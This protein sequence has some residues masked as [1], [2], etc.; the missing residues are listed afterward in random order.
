MKTTHTNPTQA[1]KI[2]RFLKSGK[3][4]TAMQALVKFGCF[5]LAARVH[6]LKKK[7]HKI[8]MTTKHDR[9]TN[10]KFASYSI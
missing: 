9:K 3:T 5:R 8:K 6:E 1:N 7:G 10:K 2:L 4:I